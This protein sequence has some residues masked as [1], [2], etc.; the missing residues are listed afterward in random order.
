MNTARRA[1]FVDNLAA[2]GGTPSSDRVLHVGR[3]NIPDRDAVLARVAEALDRRWLSNDGPMVR[4]FEEV[5]EARHGVRHCVAVANATQGLGIAAKA[6]GLRGEVV[7]PAF[8]FVATA[9]SLEWQGITP[10][11]CDVDRQSHQ[12][13][14]AAVEAVLTE[15]TTGILAAHTWGRP[16]DIE[17]LTELAARHD[18]ELFFDAA[19]A[20]GAA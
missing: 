14:P 11:F 7:V 9:H 16:C 2:F 12:L 19:P 5:V 13:D 4:E 3:P 10:V 8:T 6:L 17:R 18:L 15:R 1:G 20:Y